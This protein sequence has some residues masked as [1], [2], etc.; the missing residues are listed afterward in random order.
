VQSILLEVNIGG[1][2]AKSGI[3]PEKIGELLEACALHKSIKLEGLMT[4]PPAAVSPRDTRRYFDQMY[5]LFVDIKTKKYDNNS[6][7]ILSMG[8]SGD[9]EEAILAGA[10]MVRLGSAIFGPRK[11]T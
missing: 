5:K 10:N 4:I 11:A 1:E 2:Q 3:E 6:M 7:G 9:Y 8:M